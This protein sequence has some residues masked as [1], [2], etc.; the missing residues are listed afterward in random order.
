MKVNELLPHSQIADRVQRRVRGIGSVGNREENCHTR[1]LDWKWPED[2]VGGRIAPFDLLEMVPEAERDRLLAKVGELAAG[3]LVPVDA[4][5]RGREPALE[6]PVEQADAFEVGL[7]IAE[8]VEGEPRR[9][10]RA[11]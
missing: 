6:G 1:E 8:R 4:S 10:W 5:G 2:L 3:D 9:A 7:E 11:R